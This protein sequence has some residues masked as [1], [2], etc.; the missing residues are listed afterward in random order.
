MLRKNARV[1]SWLRVCLVM[2]LALAIGAPAPSFADPPSHAPAYG[3]RAK[4]GHGRADWDDDDD[5]NHH[6][7]DCHRYPAPQPPRDYGI[8]GGR[9]HRDE[10]GMVLGGV[11]GGAIGSTIGH[12][13]DRAVAILVGGI[14]GAV[15]GHEVGRAMD[16]RDRACFAQTLEL[17]GA[18]Q[19]VTW[20][21]EATG[22]TYV[23]TPTEA[24]Q[25]GCRTFRFRTARGARY[26][27]T[28]GRAC[29]VSN[30]T[31]QAQPI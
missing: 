31:W 28:Q 10:I 14:L 29:R 15:V 26:D 3:W 5:D 7:H 12:G 23:V 2:M 30:G 21:N 20:V 1:Y 6:H 24:A 13:S 25:Q 19:S 4:H 8:Y 9:C 11:V 18:G 27:T 22:I 17:A 16:E